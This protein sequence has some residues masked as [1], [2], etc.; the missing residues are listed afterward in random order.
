M[1]R[2]VEDQVENIDYIEHHY[3]ISPAFE[4]LEQLQQDHSSILEKINKS[5]NTFRRVHGPSN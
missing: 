1:I 2:L 4:Q 3:V 5:P